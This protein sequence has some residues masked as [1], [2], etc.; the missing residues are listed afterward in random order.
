MAE[1]GSTDPGGIDRG[2]LLE[3]L[4]SEGAEAKPGF[5]AAATAESVPAANPVV[6]ASASL[7]SVGSASAS[8]GSSSSTLA[9]SLGS[10]GSASLAQPVATSS[11]TSVSAEASLS[12]EVA[13]EARGSVATGPVLSSSVGTGPG[14]G[15]GSLMGSLATAP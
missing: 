10:V 3:N 2:E 11:V 12:P 15:S 6:A 8:L 9:S 5:V 7:G 13:S 1:A 14:S 4:T